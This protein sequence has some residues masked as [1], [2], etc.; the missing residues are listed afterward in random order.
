MVRRIISAVILAIALTL[1]A[2]GADAQGR[3]A[4]GEG[5]AAYDAGDYE[6]AARL[7]RGLAEAGDAGAQ[8]ALADLYALGLGVAANSA[9]AAEWYLRAARKGQII[10]QMNLGEFYATG[11]G[12]ERDSVRAL[13]W[14][15]LAAGR[16]HMWARRRHE[17]LSKVAT[18]AQREAA[19]R[20]APQ[21]L[22]NGD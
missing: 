19:A 13:A 20:L 7:W 22:G 16:G 1:S 18:A 15:S 5:L 10:A 21:L 2:V 6:T 11:R 14:F 12:V 3:K 17:E 4:F 9:V 8:S